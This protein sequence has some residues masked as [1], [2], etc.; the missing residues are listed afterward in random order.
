MWMWMWMWGGREAEKLHWRNFPRLEKFGNCQKKK[1]C[2]FSAT[3]TAVAPRRQQ[4]L[5]QNN[6]F[7]F[8]EKKNILLGNS[9][10]ITVLSQLKKKK[11]PVFLPPNILGSVSY[12]R[13][14]KGRGRKWK[15]GEPRIN[16]RTRKNKEAQHLTSQ[17][18]S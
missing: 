10:V 17:T 4:M 8:K 11:S 15:E 14:R 7:C 13:V 18:L 3:E 5:L 12:F 6:Y 1:N 2:C 16:Q 9:C